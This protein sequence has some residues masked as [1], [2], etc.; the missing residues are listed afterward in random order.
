[1][2]RSLPNLWFFGTWIP[3]A[4]AFLLVIQGLVAPGGFGYESGSHSYELS[5]AAGVLCFEFTEEFWAGTTTPAPARGPD[6]FE[7]VTGRGHEFFNPRTLGFD[8][9][10]V[11]IGH[12]GRDWNM[13]Y[14][15]IPHWSI[16]AMLSI[17]P[18]WRCFAYSRR[19]RSP[20]SGCAR[21]GYDLRAQIAGIAGTKCPECGCVVTKFK[22]PVMKPPE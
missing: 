3:L 12:G 17:Y 19:Q 14:L 18:V 9:Y 7:F 20:A 5:S 13:H 11:G 15:M 6:R 8:Y 2:A 21:C 16:L 1:M 10:N 22:E 4:F